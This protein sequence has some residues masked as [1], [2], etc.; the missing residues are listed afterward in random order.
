MVDWVQMAQS[1]LRYNVV[2]DGKFF[3]KGIWVS[4]AWKKERLEEF[5][6]DHDVPPEMIPSVE[7]QRERLLRDQVRE[8][9]M[10][11]TLE[12]ATSTQRSVD[13]R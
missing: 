8:G 4:E 1:V 10:C 5:S 12:H 6:D 7:K 11:A 9:A 13:V 2:I 3:N